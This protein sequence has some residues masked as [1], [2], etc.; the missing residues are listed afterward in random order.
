MRQLEA[1][2]PE[3]LN[4]SCARCFNSNV[5]TTTWKLLS[6]GDDRCV[7]QCVSC[8]TE[9]VTY[10]LRLEPLAKE[11]KQVPPTT[12]ANR[13]SG[14]IREVVT[15]AKVT[16]VGQVPQWM[17]PVPRL[18]QRALGPEGIEHYRKGSACVREGVGIGAAAY[19]RRLVEDHV[20]DI[21]KV[22]EEADAPLG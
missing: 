2:L 5:P 15:R 6:A 18:L 3:V 11:R 12:L 19:F 17:A 1:V 21:L 9:T 13:L 8:S 10:Y 16:K 7:Y 4:A 20:D 22:V 14:G